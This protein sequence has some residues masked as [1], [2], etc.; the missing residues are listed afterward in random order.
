MASFGGWDGA[1]L[2]EKCADSAQLAAAYRKV[3]DAYQLKAPVCG[4]SSPSAPSRTAPTC[5]APT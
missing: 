3:I 4:S 5:P 1:K 2:G